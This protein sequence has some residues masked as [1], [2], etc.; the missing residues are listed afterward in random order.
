MNPY[1]IWEQI[2]LQSI[3][4]SDIDSEQQDSVKELCDRLSTIQL[5]LP[6]GLEPDTEFE[7]YVVGNLCR[8]I[9]DI[10]TTHLFNR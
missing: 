8:Q 10:L 4:L 9:E 6:D 1:G 7:L 5:L 2:Y 3:R